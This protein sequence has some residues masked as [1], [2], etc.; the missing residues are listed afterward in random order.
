VDCTV[1]IA[2]LSEYLDL[3]LV[4]DARRDIEVHLERCVE[5]RVC[6]DTLRK[7]I[8]LYRREAER[9]CPEQVRIRLHAILAY[10]YRK[11]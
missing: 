10:E 3:E 11:K 9:E 1:V 8:A 2:R 5:C 6:V 4:E 7:T